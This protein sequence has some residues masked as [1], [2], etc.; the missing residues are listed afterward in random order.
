MS[1]RKQLRQCFSDRDFLRSVDIDDIL[2]IPGLALGPP[3]NGLLAST[4]IH[5][6]HRSDTKRRIF[7]I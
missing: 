6:G 1:L 7:E 2:F 3:C 5:I 4:F